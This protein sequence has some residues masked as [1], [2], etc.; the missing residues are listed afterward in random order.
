MQASAARKSYYILYI[1]CYFPRA[2]ILL[3]MVTF[4]RLPFYERSEM[5]RLSRTNPRFIGMPAPRPRGFQCFSVLVFQ[6]FSVIVFQCYSVS[7]PAP[8]PRWLA[9]RPRGFQ[10]FSVSVFQCLPRDLGGFSVLVFQCFSVSVL[11]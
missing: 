10:C 6:G 7:V 8:K 4:V 3:Y 2:T 9:P 1:I 11:L 5:K